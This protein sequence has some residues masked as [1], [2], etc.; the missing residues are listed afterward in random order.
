[1]GGLGVAAPGD[2]GRRRI[3]LSA[4]LLNNRDRPVGDWIKAIVFAA[5][6]ILVLWATALGVN[7]QVT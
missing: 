4:T 7:S 6:N 2:C 1:M 5:V 3:G